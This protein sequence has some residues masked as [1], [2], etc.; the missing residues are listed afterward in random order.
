MYCNKT[1]YCMYCNKAWYSMYCNKAP[2]AID[3][4][5]TARYVGPKTREHSVRRAAA[6]NSTVKCQCC[7]I[8]ARAQ[9]G[10][11]KTWAMRSASLTGS[12]LFLYFSKA[13]NSVDST[14]SH[15]GTLPD[16]SVST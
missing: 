8:A 16:M 5:A 10:T 14:K 2:R 12:V 13:C 15:I 6:D 9:A 7:S 1:S 11:A 3:S 4:S